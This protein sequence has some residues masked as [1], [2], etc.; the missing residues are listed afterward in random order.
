MTKQE[1]LRANRVNQMPKLVQVMAGRLYDAA[2]EAGRKEGYRQGVDAVALKEQEIHKAMYE[3]GAQDATHRGSAAFT[4]AACK[5]LR[6]LYKFGPK[7]LKTVVDGIAEELMGMLDPAEAVREV[8]SWGIHIE[9]DDELAGE[10]DGW[11]ETA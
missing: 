10:L 2:F 3:H 9:Y 4:V 6:R 11:E 8:R 7:R 1:F 5:V